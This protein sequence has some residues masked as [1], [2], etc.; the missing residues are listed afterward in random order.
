[1]GSRKEWYQLIPKQG[2]WEIIS[3]KKRWVL[4]KPEEALILKGLKEYLKLDRKSSWMVMREVLTEF[5]ESK[6]ISKN[7]LVMALSLSDNSR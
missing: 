7:D 2:K 6:G 3:K 4:V 5:L 1:M